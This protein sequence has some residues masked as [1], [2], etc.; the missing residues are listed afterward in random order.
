MQTG[1]NTVD[2]YLAAQPDVLRATLE[3]LRQVIKKA[4]PEAQELISYSMPAY[5]Y[6]GMV[7]Y[8]AA[9]KNH[10][11]LYVMPRV[12]ESFRS[13][14]GTYKLSKSTIQFPWKTPLPDELVAE[15]IQYAVRFNRE[16]KELKD[17]SKRR[18][19]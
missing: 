6:L 15:I 13:R 3:H 9:A 19:T 16:Q 12:L 4:A 17:A 18:K 11:G 5:K 2:E 7:A 8:F 14:L 1:F 10:Y